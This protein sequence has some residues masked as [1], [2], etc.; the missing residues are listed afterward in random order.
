[1]TSLSEKK[2]EQIKEMF[3]NISPRYDLANTFLSF[4]LYK[5]WYKL[6]IKRIMLSN[7]LKILDCATGTG[8]IPILLAQSGL[9]LCICGVDFSDKMLEV[10]RKRISKRNLSVGLLHADILELPFDKDYF[11]V[12]TICFGIRN[13][14]DAVLCLKEMSKVV[15]SGGKVLILEFGN[16][17]GIVK[18]LYEPYRKLIMPVVGRI[19]TGDREAYYYLADSTSKFPSGEN[20]IEIMKRTNQ[21]KKIN[22]L[23]I[24]RGVAYIYEGI[25]K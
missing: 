20:F 23:P 7:G 15:K 14:T 16:P 8:N 4:G 24:F 11:D 9:N 25:V 19:V 3:S 6:L 22:M 1:M 21:F 10:A 13:V 17:T 2:P 5:I 12:A 18:L